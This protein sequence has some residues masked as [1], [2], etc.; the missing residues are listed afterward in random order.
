MAAMVA[1]GSSQLSSSISVQEKGSRNKRKFHADQPLGDPNKLTP[2][3]QPECTAC[4]EL[5]KSQNSLASEQH[6]VC[7]LR[8]FQQDQLN[9]LTSDRGSSSDFGCELPR[10][11]LEVEFRDNVDWS[12]VTETQLEELVLCHL[13]TI[14]KS[15]IRRIA[16]HVHSED[17]ATQAVMRP[18][19][20]Y[21]CKDIVSNIVDNALAF[22]RNGQEIDSSKDCI[23]EDLQHLEKYILVEMVCVLMEVWPTFSMGD[24]MWRLLICDMNMSDACAVDGNLLGSFGSDE[25]AGSLSVSTVSQAISEAN[26]S[27]PNGPE[28]SGVRPSKPNKLNPSGPELPSVAGIPNLPSARFSALGNAPNLEKESDVS[29]ADHGEESSSFTSDH[30]PTMPRSSAS[31]LSWPDDKT[32][33]G[34][35]GHIN[36]SKRDSLFR[37]KSIHLEKSYRAYG[38]KVALRSGKL[39]GLTSF[40]MDKKCKPVS[41][42]AISNLKN[43]SLKVSKVVGV[44]SSQI[45]GIANLSINVGSTSDLGFNT[46][47]NSNPSMLPVASTELTLSLPSKNSGASK[48]D[49]NVETDVS[50][51]GIS[52]DN[53]FGQWPPQDKKDEMLLKLDS[54]VRELQIQ[55]QEWR[56]WGEHKV[57]DAARKLS[58]DNA[59]LKMLRQEKEEVARIKKEKQT[60][61]E[62]TMKKLSE[63]EN[64]LGKA[65]RQVDMA[66]ATVRRREVENSE[67]RQE[68]EAAKLRAAELAARHEEVS[69][70]EK[71]T[72]KKYES[73]EKLKTFFQEELL[74]EK[75]K[76]SRL[77]QQL[78]QAKEYHDQLEA[79][80][81]QEERLKEEAH[82][83][84]DSERKAREQIEASAKLKEDKIRL[85]AETDFQRYRN[86]MGRL[87]IE[88]AQ[89][90]LK[91]DSS[92]I[93]ALHWGVDG[94]YAS[95]LTDVRSN[96]SLKENTHY[97]SEMTD[98]Q[99][100][101]IGDVWCELECVMCLTE[102][103]SVV[104]LP[105]AHQ[106][107]CTK[108]NELHEKQGMKD[109]PS[110]RTPIQQRI[111]A[112]FVHS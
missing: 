71:K 2:P 108:C 73:W 35:K 3:S 37:Q 64:A 72:L 29:L 20:Y 44:G 82:L 61:E 55:M 69:R 70:R 109:C 80:R 40:F 17:V 107:V 66:N 15:A 67:L 11:E 68:M 31:R 105:C 16:T 101:G 90:R 48:P 85:E 93:A 87:E 84:A 1:R 57:M 65:S 56:E 54:R 26:V 51:S 49:G 102:E 19:L 36:S 106:V 43:A 28:A 23:F 38:S 21:G 103:M 42:A 95:R 27:V 12:D 100:S 4:C 111:C 60:L 99:D 89:V 24:A 34:R 76:L 77:Q 75:S 5:E 86:D 79:R 45:D 18:G 104:F 39:N 10:D 94:S 50:C 52:S 81:K 96:H 74:T 110:C 83:L 92:K 14:Y 7:D 32:G 59:E 22:L 25:A 46:K 13:D 97:I 91:A 58:K 98:F 6:A 41:E 53:I 112:R 62:N 47:E 8:G 78:E 88:I 9:G 33:G 63:M 30:V